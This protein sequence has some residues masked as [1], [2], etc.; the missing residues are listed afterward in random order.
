MANIIHNVVTIY[1]P[2][3]ALSK[4]VKVGM[5]GTQ[6]IEGKS[7]Y[8]IAVENGFEGTEADWLKS[9]KGD[10]FTYSDF[11]AEQ[12]HGL[13]GPQGATGPIGPKGPQ[14][15][16]GV[17]G[18]QGPKGDKGD[19]GDTGPQGIQGIQGIQ[20]LKG[21]KGDTGATGPEGPQG[22]IGLTGP[23]GLKGDKGDPFA[24]YKT[25]PS[26]TEMEADAGRVADGLFVIIA[27]SP[28]DEDNAKLYVKGAN[29]FIFITDLSGMQGIK[30]DKGD[31][32][33]QG[34]QGPQGEIGPQ[35]TQ[36]EKGNPGDS[37]TNATVNANGHLILTIG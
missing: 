12:L 19:K 22:P 18:E 27:S 5:K 11:T 13:R 8:T 36:G 7:A 4:V 25:Y 24:I 14:G 31:K 1:V 17:Q 20:G 23:E 29:G 16:Q 10:A 9:L 34:E 30:G 15:I 3:P 26:I 33:I 2:K 28:E 37:L 21:D 32:G 35:G 6:G